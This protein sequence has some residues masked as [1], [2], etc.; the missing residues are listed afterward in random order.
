MLN[1][2]ISTVLETLKYN[3]NAIHIKY[4]VGV[5]GYWRS[6]SVRTNHC[7]PPAK[8]SW[9]RACSIYAQTTKTGHAILPWNCDYNKLV[10][11][12]WTKLWNQ[13]SRNI[14]HCPSGQAFYLWCRLKYRMEVT[15]KKK[16]PLV[17]SLERYPKCSSW[18]S[19]GMEI[20]HQGTHN[21]VLRSFRAYACTEKLVWGI[22]YFLCLFLPFL[23]MN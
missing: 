18:R 23:S 22:F 3:Q 13:R 2:W 21:L 15:R 6:L 8:C 10:T 11:L 9:R 12:Q 16:V 4:Q 14:P 1:C 19:C 5:L 20:N 17:Q 7:L